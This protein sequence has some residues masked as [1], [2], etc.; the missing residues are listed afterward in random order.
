MINKIKKLFHTH[1][2]EMYATDRY[3]SRKWKAV[4]EKGFYICEGCGEISNSY[5]IQK[6]LFRDRKLPK[7]AKN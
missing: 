2:F 6:F 5:T 7:Y 1:N 4:T 3:Y